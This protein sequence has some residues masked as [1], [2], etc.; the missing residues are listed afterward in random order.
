MEFVAS[1]LVDMELHRIADP[2]AIDVAAFEA[3]T[4]AAI[5]MPAAMAARHATP[6]FQHIFSGGGYSAGYY[7]YLWSEILDADGFEAF[8]ESGDDFDPALA[9]RLKQFVYSAGNLREPDE[10]YRAF[11]GRDPA[12]DALL[13][14]R[15]LAELKRRPAPDCLPPH[16]SWWGHGMRSEARI[17]GWPYCSVSS[18]V[19]LLFPLFSVACAVFSPVFVTVTLLP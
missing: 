11:R 9:A 12:P 6:H 18:A 4:L 3:R 13:R 1:A 2:S 5:G 17:G 8:E 19:A 16:T 10:A 15:G 14:K 7:S